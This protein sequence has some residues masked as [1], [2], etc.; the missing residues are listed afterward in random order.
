MREGLCGIFSKAVFKG[1]ELQGFGT[2]L[3]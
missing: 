2:I 1:L 3:S